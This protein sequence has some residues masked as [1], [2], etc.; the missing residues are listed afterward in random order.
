MPPNYGLMFFSLAHTG[1]V[2]LTS[3]CIINEDPSFCQEGDQNLFINESG[4]LL[5]TLLSIIT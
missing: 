4:H 3:L 2:R 5:I 1:C